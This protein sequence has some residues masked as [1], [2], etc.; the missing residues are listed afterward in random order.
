LTDFSWGELETST[1]AWNDMRRD[2]RR[3]KFGGRENLS[4]EVE[5]KGTLGIKR[6]W[7]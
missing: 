4:G 6:V 7:G 5:E 3:G 2:R 1:K